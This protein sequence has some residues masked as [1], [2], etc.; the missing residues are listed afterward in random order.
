MTDSKPE[1]YVVHCGTP[2]VWTYRFRG[3]EWY[4]VKCKRAF[5]MFGVTESKKYTEKLEREHKENE[6]IFNESFPD[7][8]Q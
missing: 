1:E 2:L 7:D 8:R 6:R 3:K 5:K 4:C